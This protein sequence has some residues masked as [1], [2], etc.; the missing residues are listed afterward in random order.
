MQSYIPTSLHDLA[1]PYMEADRLRSGQR[2]PSFQAAV[3]KMLGATKTQTHASSSSSSSSSNSRSSRAHGKV[4]AA[5]G[6]PAISE[7]S[8][9]EDDSDDD[10]D[11]DDEEDEDDDGPQLMNGTYQLISF[12]PVSSTYSS[13][14]T[15]Y[16]YSRCGQ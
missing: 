9:E 8:N 1:N 2:E 10:D 11:D 16:L 13:S 6:I 3:D 15:N 14:I 12:I 7:D 5:R 4:K